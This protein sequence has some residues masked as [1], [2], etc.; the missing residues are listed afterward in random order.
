MGSHTKPLNTMGHPQ[1]VMQL[2]GISYNL[3]AP[4]VFSARL[5]PAVAG[6]LTIAVV[7]LLAMKLYSTKHAIAASL[8]LSIMP[9]HIRYS[10][11]LHLDS[12]LALMLSLSFL[13]F[14]I[15]FVE[16]NKS[17][18]YPVLFGVSLALAVATKSIAPLVLPAFVLYFI[19]Y[20]NEFRSEAERIGISLVAFIIIL[21][22]EVD[23]ASYIDGILN[24]TDPGYTKSFTLL[25]FDQVRRLNWY[26]NVGLYLITPPVLL[27]F[28]LGAKAITESKSKQDMLVA[29]WLAS[30]L[31]SLVGLSGEHGLMSLAA[32]LS[33]IASR[34]LD[35]LDKKYHAIALGVSIILILPFS[36]WY[37]LRFEVLPYDSYYNVGHGYAIHR[38]AVEFIINN[39]P[40]KSAIGLAAKSLEVFPR[41]FTGYQFYGKLVPDGLLLYY[42][43]PDST[44]SMLYYYKCDYYLGLEGCEAVGIL[45]AEQD[46]LKQSV[47][48]IEAA[49]NFVLWNNFT[50]ADPLG[51]NSSYFGS[52]TIL[53]FKNRR[54]DAGR[55]S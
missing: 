54:L 18:V 10:R 9:L 52:N 14:Y 28:L 25:F 51:R 15:A 11:D 34:S 44:K 12:V 43:L 1:F 37:G 32:P 35:K 5:V 6:I 8:V 17:L 36:L 30:L 31:P 33:I 48:E 49:T 55:Q 20:R 7:F 29:L 26:A 19:L 39:A 3:F 22:A 45:I 21:L 4:S 40:N 53:I 23:P 50:Y 41:L 47:S 13:F 42:R 38:D 27:G 16:K 2:L 24:P 46:V